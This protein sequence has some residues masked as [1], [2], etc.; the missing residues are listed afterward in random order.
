MKNDRCKNIFYIFDVNCMK[1]VLNVELLFRWVEE[2]NRKCECECLV[3]FLFVLCFVC[4]LV[5]LFGFGFLGGG[6]G[7]YRDLGNLVYNLIFKFR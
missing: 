4:R 2:Y 1:Y 3:D 5:Y 6:G 7:E